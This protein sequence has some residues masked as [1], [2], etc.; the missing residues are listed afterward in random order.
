[1]S[2]V[3]TA[4]D[5]RSRRTRHSAATVAVLPEPTGPPKPIRRARRLP[6]G[7]RGSALWVWRCGRVTGWS[8]CTGAPGRCGGEGSGG[9][10]ADGPGGVLLAGDVQQRGGRGGQDGD[11]LGGHALRRAGRGTGDGVAL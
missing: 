2:L 6:S 11:A 10:E 4:R 8:R 7:R 1:M 5:S 3:T 9:E